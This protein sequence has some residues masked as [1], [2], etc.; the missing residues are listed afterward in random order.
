MAQ[1]HT[2]EVWIENDKIE[3]SPAGGDFTVTGEGTATIL[4]KPRDGKIGWIFHDFEIVA[5]SGVPN[6]D[7]FTWSRDDHKIEL[8]DHVT[9]NGH[10]THKIEIDR[11]GRILTDDPAIPNTHEVGTAPTVS[12]GVT[13]D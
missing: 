7:V 11:G 8:T 13:V 2:V 5:E 4:F 3:K 10:Y 12:A 9:W 6:G 1:D